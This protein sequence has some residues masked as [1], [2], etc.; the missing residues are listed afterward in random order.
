MAH[1]KGPLEWHCCDFAPDVEGVH[2][3]DRRDIAEG[4]ETVQKRH[5]SELVPHHDD[6]SVFGPHVPELAWNSLQRLMTKD[7]K[8]PTR[9]E[10]QGFKALIEG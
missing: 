9:E 2:Y 5:I 3:P 7:G 8:Y 6:D 10:L 1:K 4:E